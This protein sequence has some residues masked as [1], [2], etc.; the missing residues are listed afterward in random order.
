M[1][2]VLIAL[3]YGPTAQTVAEKGFK[4]AKELSS[5]IVLLHVVEDPAYYSAPEYS[6]IM[7][8]SGFNVA[9]LQDALKDVK[10]SA[11][12]FLNKVKEHL[13]DDNVGIMVQDGEIAKTIISAAKDIE[14]DIIIMGSHG[15]RW[16][17]K[18]LMGSVTEEVLH[19]ITIPLY[20]IPTAKK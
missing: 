9:S 15:R 18:I 16:L 19:S 4:L 17:D 7:G 1:K 3:D 13:G 2:K 8:F 12:G 10:S 5:E 6:P 11:Q 14:A 20:I